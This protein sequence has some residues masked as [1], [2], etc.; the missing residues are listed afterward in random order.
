MTNPL[1]PD[2]VARACRH[3]RHVDVEFYLDRGGNID[4]R[5]YRGG[6]LLMFAARYGREYIV[7]MLIQ[8]G[9][10]IDMRNWWGTAL[11]AASVY[12]HVVV[13]QQ[14]L[15]AGASIEARNVHG[16]TAL[17]LAEKE[18]HSECVHLLRMAENYRPALARWKGHARVVGSAAGPHGDPRTAV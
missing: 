15:A 11:M 1:I 14:L 7:R 9:A 4:G 18:S 8:E 17:L 6:T 3:G 16:Q 13:V 5:D 12:G 2:E 10:T